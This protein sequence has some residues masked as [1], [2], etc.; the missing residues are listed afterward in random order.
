MKNIIVNSNS[1]KQLV[2]LRKTVK[3]SWELNSTFV[4]TRTLKIFYVD[5]SKIEEIIGFFKIFFDA[6][7]K[8]DSDEIIIRL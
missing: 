7:V 5:E 3:G 2:A 1:L 4:N 8:E 6:K